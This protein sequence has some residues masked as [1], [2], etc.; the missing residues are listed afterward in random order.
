MFEKVWKAV[1][2]GRAHTSISALEPAILVVNLAGTP[3]NPKKETEGI[4]TCK[5]IELW[6]SIQN[7]TNQRQVEGSNFDLH[8]WFNT[9]RVQVVRTQ[10]AVDGTDSFPLYFDD[11]V[12]TT[13]KAKGHSEARLTRMLLNNEVMI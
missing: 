10:Q 9:T 5:V 12:G 3:I 13:Q 11:P 4:I 6:Q 7:D 8:L 2:V 1:V